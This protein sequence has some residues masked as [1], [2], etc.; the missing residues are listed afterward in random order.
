MDKFLER[1]KLPNLIQEKI[2]NLSNLILIKEIG[3]LVV[4]LK[5][6]ASLDDFTGEFYQTFKEENIINSIQNTF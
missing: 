2:D 4:S 1:H 5:K 6:I 3:Y